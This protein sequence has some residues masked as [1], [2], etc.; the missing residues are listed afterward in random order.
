MPLAPA[1]QFPAKGGHPHVAQD[2]TLAEPK[3]DAAVV[4]PS[5]LCAPRQ[6]A[7]LIPAAEPQQVLQPP[8]IPLLPAGVSPRPSV[9][10]GAPG[11]ALVSRLMDLNLEL[12]EFEIWSLGLWQAC[13]TQEENGMECKP[14]GSLLALPLEL[15]ASVVLMLASN[16]LGFFA[17]ILSS[18]GLN[19]L[20]TGDERLKRGLGVAG[21]ALFCVAGVTTLVPISWVAYCTVQEFWDA[22]VPE[23]VSRGKMQVERA[24]P[25]SAERHKRLQ[26]DAQQEPLATA[27]VPTVVQAAGD[28]QPHTKPHLEVL[29]PKPRK[30]SKLD[31]TTPSSR[32]LQLAEKEHVAAL[33]LHSP[34]SVMKRKTIE[35]GRQPSNIQNFYCTFIKPDKEGKA[36]S[37]VGKD[38]LQN[39]SECPSRVP[40]HKARTPKGALFLL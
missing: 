6:C 20:K 38:T 27:G 25:Y 35:E 2:R 40:V 28:H 31:A 16:G 11:R 39:L 29:Q 3:P 26:A 8:Q 33:R 34:N 4:L 12:N 22:T 5:H 15:R 18:L 1:L 9:S 37:A 19:C 24:L 7:Y 17:L 14:H 36:T 13:V 32:G 23:I 10:H 30:Q 21:G